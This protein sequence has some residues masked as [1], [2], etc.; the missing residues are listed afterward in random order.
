MPVLTYTPNLRSN[1]RVGAVLTG[2]T[3]SHPTPA[4]FPMTLTARAMAGRV[5]IPFNGGT[6]SPARG[7]SAVVPST[8]Y[9]GAVTA[10]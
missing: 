1:S 8:F 9:W 6:Y 10:T 7:G 3:F 4:P 2:A 5:G